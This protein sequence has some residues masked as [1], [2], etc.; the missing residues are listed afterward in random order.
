MRFIEVDLP[1]PEGPTIET[2]SLRPMV[3]FDALESLHFH[4]AGAVDLADRG[5]FD[6]YSYLKDSAGLMD[7]A[8]R[9]GK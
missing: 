5:H 6:H 1:E 7:A 2:Y 9:A 8:R 4:P 3:R